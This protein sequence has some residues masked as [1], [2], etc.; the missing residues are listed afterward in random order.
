MVKNTLQ[1]LKEA[2]IEWINGYIDWDTSV[3]LR[4]NRGVSLQRVGSDFHK[5]GGQLSRGVLGSNYS[6]SRARCPSV[7]G[8]IEG[9]PSAQTIHLHLMV[10]WPD[11][12]RLEGHASH[13]ER[14]RVAWRDTVGDSSSTWAVPK[15]GTQQEYVSYCM[16][17]LPDSDSFSDRLVEY[18][19]DNAKRVELT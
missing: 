6:R 15:V 10:W 5:F 7:F 18:N 13:V 9:D 19:L 16:K 2:N 1:V 3:T 12:V 17:K 11:D 14:I 4:Y 8:M